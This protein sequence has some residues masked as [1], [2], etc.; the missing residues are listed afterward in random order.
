MVLISENCLSLCL[1]I[2]IGMSLLC[3]LSS[4]AQSPQSV[5]CTEFCNKSRV[6][7]ILLLARKWAWRALMAVRPGKWCE[8]KPFSHKALHMSTIFGHNLWERMCVVIIRC[9]FWY[10]SFDNHT[11]WTQVVFCIVARRLGV[12]PDCNLTSFMDSTLWFFSLMVFS[13]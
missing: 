7:V 2:F 10:M 3:S 5:K 13:Y 11:T 12:A 9:T 4:E 6:G 1:E 8:K